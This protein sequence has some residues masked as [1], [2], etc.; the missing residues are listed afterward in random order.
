MLKIKKS[1]FFRIFDLSH[2][3]V[4]KVNCVVNMIEIIEIY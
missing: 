1:T 3:T 4:W 2:I